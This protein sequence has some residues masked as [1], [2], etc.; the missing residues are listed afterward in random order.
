[1]LLPPG[2]VL[3]C[4]D[5]AFRRFE[6][7]TLD[8]TLKP[9]FPKGIGT[10]WQPNPGSEASSLPWGAR[11]TLVVRFDHRPLHNVC[12]DRGQCNAL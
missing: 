1:M 4:Q 10:M 3:V 5:F 7:E 12:G 11:F 2:F 8:D 6:I 9:V